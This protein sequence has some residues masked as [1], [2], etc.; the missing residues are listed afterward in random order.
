MARNKKEE[1]KE[2]FFE[3][4]ETLN[5]EDAV[6]ERFGRFAKYNIQSRALPDARDGLKPVQR[7]I[8]YSM[9]EEGNIADKPYRKSA[10]SVGNIMGNYHPHGDCLHGDT[11]VRLTNGE[12]K[13]MKE[14]FDL[15]QDVEI[16][17]V[18]KNNNIVPAIAHAFRIGQYA[19]EI[20]HITLSDGRTI[21]TTSNHPFL[22]ASDFSSEGHKWVKAEDLK[23]SDVLYS[24]YLRKSLDGYL[25]MSC[26]YS[27]NFT[28][29]K[30]IH[31]VFGDLLD[32]TENKIIHHVDENKHNNSSNNLIKLTRAEHAL[33]HGDYFKG[34]ELGRER[35]STDLREKMRIKNS[36]LMK[37]F[38]ANQGLFKAFKIIDVLNERG[39]KITEENY[40]EVREEF[41]NYPMISNMVKKGQITDFSDLLTMYNKRDEFEI[42]FDKSIYAEI[43][44]EEKEENKDLNRNL[45]KVWETRK[46][47]QV[48][49][50]IVDITVEKVIKQP[51]YDFTVDNHENMLLFQE[52]ENEYNSFIVAHNSSIYEAMA[53]LAQDWIQGQVLVDMHGNKG[54]I[55]GDGAA[56]MRYTES[57]LEKIVT[58]AV[59]NG[60][61]KKGV[62][63]FKNNFDDSAQE[64]VLLPVQ[65]P[66]LLVNGVEGISTG[67]ATR[68]PTHNLKELLQA[69]IELLKNPDMTIDELLEIIP[70]PDFPTGGVVTNAKTLR[71]VYETGKGGITI[72]SKYHIE[73]I[74]NKKLIVID[75]IPYG[76]IKTN[77]VTKISDLIYDKKIVGVTNVRDESD[78]TGMRVVIE[79]AK[80][81]DLNIIIPFLMKNTSMQE[82]FPTNMVAIVDKKPKLLGLRELLVRFN[83]FRVE[84]RTNELQYDLQKFQ[85]RLH[86][87]EGFIKLSD[88]IDDVVKMI[89]EADGKADSKNK[90]VANFGFSEVQA[91]SIV[92]VQLYRISKTDKKAYLEEQ[93]KLNRSIKVI[94][95]LL[96]S[97]IKLRNNII[98]MYTDIIEKYGKDRKTE[99]IMEE[100]KWEVNV[101]DTIAEEDV[102][103]S[104]SQQ[105]YVKRSTPRS[106]GSSAKNGLAK[107]DVVLLETK[108][109]TKENLVVFTSK[110]RFINL[111]IHTLDE[112]RWSD[113][114]K[115][116]SS[117][118][119]LKDGEIVINAF[120]LNLEEEKA[121][122]ILIAKNDGKVKRTTVEEHI[123]LS[124]FNKP[125]EAVKKI[126]DNSD[127]EVIGVW[128]VEDTGFIGFKDGKG[129]S[130]YFSIDE[131][132]PTGLKTD[133]MRGIHI[134]D[135]DKVSE[136]V[137]DLLESNMPMGY[138]AR[139]RGSKGWYK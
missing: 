27:E 69:C 15:G 24:G 56:S 55:D 117:I 123:V 98:K 57:R 85:E 96:G 11:E 72:R 26:K 54:S 114:G 87:V 64:P 135:N 52:S 6:S 104:V 36:Q 40:T 126:A 47:L 20:Y 92:V 16:F 60:V 136:V 101:V 12:V 45:N 131:I 32:N 62:V 83:D 80:D 25:D 74:K 134:E 82:S 70:A 4:F 14:L 68:I 29:L 88:I 49:I 67:Y 51:M 95:G 133:G 130:M 121:R 91:E 111:P 107:D 59:L 42:K 113:I 65:F 90:L 22:L 75:E 13:T 8:L 81:A 23:V 41:Y 39:L 17:A 106:Y 120:A 132:N 124:K 43:G 31:K 102:Y 97:K 1:E 19:D 119:P 118:A 30:A 3:N 122:Y 58:D 10:K 94:E 48:D 86:I 129:R 18:D 109:N 79:C 100:E 50:T 21:S 125:Y 76:V 38:K 112:V 71:E 103:I 44:L 34:L 89:K 138:K 77:I 99:V 108:S 63:P 33:I 5:A 137:F 115:H 116:V 78:R 105:G 84:T 2:I 93:D 9:F 61:N 139:K 37:N 53:R 35:M 127:V 73:E 7:R 110:G 66:L 128:L 46:E 28:N